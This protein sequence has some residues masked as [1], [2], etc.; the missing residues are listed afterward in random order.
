M[1]GQA[2][3][4][5]GAAEFSRDTDIV[6]LA[7]E[8]NLARLTDALERLEAKLIAVPEL[9]IDMLK[10][11]HAVHFRCQHPDVAGI[12]LDVMSVLRGIDPFDIL[13]KRRTTVE[14]KDNELIDLLSLTDLVTSKKTQ[15]DKDWPMLRRLVEAHAAK[16]KDH[17]ETLQIEFWLKEARTPE[18]L[19]HVARRFPECAQKLLI[20]RPLL[21]AAMDGNIPLLQKKLDAEEKNERE[22]DRNYWRP[23]R[24]ELEQLRRS[25]HN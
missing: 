25:R 14:T 19:V 6:I 11:G 12:R 17:P 2:C 21:K 4:L 7:E 18:L 10:R 8:D 3:V 24:K 20:H 15:R 16:Y 22:R 13:W 23:L 1:G 9:S 5:Y